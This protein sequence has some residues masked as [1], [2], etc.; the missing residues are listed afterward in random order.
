VSVKVG[1]F[2]ATGYAGR[3][4]VRLMA[5]HPEAAVAFTTGT[6]EGHVPHEEAI[7]READAYQLS[8]PHGIAAGYV[9]RLRDAH[10]E[11][12]II[13]LSGDLRLPTAEAYKRWYGHD[14]PAPQL[15]VEARFGLTEVYRDRIRGARLVSNPGCYATSMM[16]PLVPLL[17]DGLI[18]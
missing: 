9:A 17:K 12:V 13:D 4:I 11:A 7:P 2:G 16:L 10:P 14:H 18:E 15:L 3:E 5:S 1:V 8:L 6:G